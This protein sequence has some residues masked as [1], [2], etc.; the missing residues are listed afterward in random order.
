MTQGHEVSFS[1][2]TLSGAYQWQVSLDGG[3]TWTDVPINSAY[4]GATT[5]ILTVSNV[6][7]SLNGAKFRYVVTDDG[8][9]ATGSAITLTVNAVLI[10]FP[11]ALAVDGTGNLYVTDSSVHTVHKI[12]TANRVS[13]LAG[14]SGSAG[15]TNGTG[16]TARFNQPS[17]ITTTA[18]GLLTVVD[19]ANTLI[20][21]VTSTGVVTTLAGSTTLRGNENGT[22]TAATF[23][24]PIGISQDSSGTFTIADATNHTLRKMTSANVVTTLAGE[25]S[26]SGSTDGAGSAARFNYP[27]GVATHSTGGIYI[28]DTTNNLIRKVT[29]AGAVTTLAGVVAVSGWQDGTGN[30]ALFNQPGGLATDTA[31]NIYVADTGNSV[32]R[33]ITP[34]GVVTTLAGLSTVGGL[35]DGT[36]GE[37]WFNQPRDVAVDVSGNVY[38]ADTGNAAIRKITPAGV[39]TTMNLTVAPSGSTGGTS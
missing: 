39:V 22:G 26:T 12:T 9:I 7:G 36:G 28:S 34:A 21:R 18:G 8:S 10:P 17:G 11:V 29:S 5:Q 3:T 35:K 31:G 23:G 20:R 33:K 1:A 32:V 37:A 24:M 4:S 16:G 2:P 19:T 27:T 6:G 38:V 14:S 30:G 13:T 25:A 15:A